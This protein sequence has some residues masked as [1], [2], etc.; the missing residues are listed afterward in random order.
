M[1]G[2][3][4]IAVRNGGFESLAGAVEDQELTIGALGMEGLVDRVQRVKFVPGVLKVAAE[5]Q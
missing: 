2:G 5:L 1:L 3:V 4:H